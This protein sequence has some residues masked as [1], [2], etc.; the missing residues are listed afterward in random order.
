MIAQL[1]ANLVGNAMAYAG[2][3]A[4]IEIGTEEDWR[5]VKLF[6]S[7][8][9][10]GI[11]DDLKEKVFEPFFRVD[12]ARTIEGSGLGLPLVKAIVDRHGA[13]LSLED[14]APGLKVVVAFPR[15]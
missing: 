10:P 12:T 9:G 15:I 6:V 1:V 11:P 14:A 7:D 13:T 5:S 8:N 4:K 2:D 3:G